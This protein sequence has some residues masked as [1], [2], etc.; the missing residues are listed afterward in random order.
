[1][2]KSVI[3][4]NHKSFQKVHQRVEILDQVVSWKI[5]EVQ[6]WIELWLS[7]RQIRNLLRSYKQNWE[8]WLVHWLIWKWPNNHIKQSD[9]NIIEDVIKQDDYKDCKPIFITEKLEEIYKIDVSKETVR[10]IMIVDGIREKGTKKHHTYR[11]KRQ[12]KSTYWEMSQFDWCYHLW[13]WEWGEERCLLVDIDDATWEVIYAKLVENEWY[14]CVVLFW[15]ER[16]RM[17]WIPK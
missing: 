17:Y 13:F 12:R 16:I 7:D 10:G 2:L 14:E 6:A 8:E 9:K 15:Q 4:M 5:S 3:P 1:M 11:M